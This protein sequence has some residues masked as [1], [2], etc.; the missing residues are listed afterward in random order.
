MSSL[1]DGVCL[2]LDSIGGQENNEP[3]MDM[4][5]NTG[6]TETNVMEILGVI[7]QNTN[8]L[9]ANYLSVSND[10]KDTTSNTQNKDT[11]VNSVQLDDTQAEAAALGIGIGAAALQ[12]LV[13]TPAS[14]F[15]DFSDEE[16][17]PHYDGNQ[18]PMHHDKK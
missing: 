17:E 18:E 9:I 12:P 7:E 13:A 6:V 4:I 15:D 3:M 14:I 10:N 5:K 1:K 16:D 8:K 11:N 2:I